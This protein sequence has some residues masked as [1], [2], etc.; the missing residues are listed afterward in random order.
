M[1]EDG[2]WELDKNGTLTYVKDDSYLDA[3]STIFPSRAGR[4]ALLSPAVGLIAFARVSTR[5]LF[6]PSHG[7]V[8]LSHQVIAQIP[9]EYLNRVVAFEVHAA[10]DYPQLIEGTYYQANTVLYCLDHQG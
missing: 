8:P 4:P 2:D 7:F 10:D 5:F 9:T 6:A 1:T 3:V